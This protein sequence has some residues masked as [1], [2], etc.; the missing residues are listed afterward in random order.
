MARPREDL[1]V[2]LKSFPGVK[3]AYFQPPTSIPEYPVIIYELDDEYVAP[4]DN[5]VYFDKKR[6]TITVIDRDPD[7]LIPDMVRDLPYSRLDRKFKYE[8]LYH[9]V[10]QTYF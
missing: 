10:Y 2:I 3:K 8:T 9:S 7:S 6:Y 1:G 4:A 5:L